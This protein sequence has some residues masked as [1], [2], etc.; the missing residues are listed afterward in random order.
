MADS[1]RPEIDLHA[2]IVISE[3]IGTAGDYGPVIGQNPDRS[4]RLAWPGLAWPG[5]AWPGL[6]WPGRAGCAAAAGT[7][8]RRCGNELPRQPKYSL[9]DAGRQASEI[10]IGRKQAK[11][12]HASGVQDIHRIDDE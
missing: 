4:Q 8:Y 10:A 12:I 6:A 1:W 7:G 3:A 2:H 11:A 9:A 5:L